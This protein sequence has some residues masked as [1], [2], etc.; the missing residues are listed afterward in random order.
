MQAPPCL[1]W[2]GFYVGGFGAYEYGVFDPSV[3]VDFE[4]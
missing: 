1:T 3:H 2:T 4:L